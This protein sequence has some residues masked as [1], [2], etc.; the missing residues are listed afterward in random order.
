MPIRSHT[1][2]RSQPVFRKIEGQILEFLKKGVELFINFENSMI[3][4]T[5]DLGWAKKRIEVPGN[6]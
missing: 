2:G 1:R 4:A 5:K 3:F 6:Y